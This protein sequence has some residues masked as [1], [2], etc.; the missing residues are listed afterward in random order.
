MAKPL[1]MFKVGGDTQ[2]ARGFSR[3]GDSVKDL[4][5]AFREIV[6]DFRDGEARQFETEGAYGSGGWEP[7][8]ESTLVHKSQEGF[9]MAIMVRT[10]RLKESLVGKAGGTI[11]ELRPLSL[12]LGTSVPYA[13]YHQ[14]GTDAMPQRRLIDLPEE[15][16]TRWTKIMHRE[17]VRQSK[18]VGRGV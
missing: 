17:L 13:G 5:G 14:D 2:L 12:R 6:K 8:A 7:L 4:R 9:P 15:Q 1:M 10:G 3:F 11:E 18:G 16:K